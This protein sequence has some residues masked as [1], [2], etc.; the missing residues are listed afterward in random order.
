MS[1]HD[2]PWKRLHSTVVYENPWIRVEDHAVVNPAGGRGQYGKVCFKSRAIG[3]APIDAADHIYL[4]GQYRYTLDSYSWELPM[5]GA[6]PGEDPLVAGQRELREETGLE[7]KRWRHLLTVHTSNSV[8]DE[9]GDVFVARELV[10]GTARP[11]PT[12]A[13]AVQRMPFAQALE[14][15]L[16][17]KIT[18]AM[19]VAAILRLAVET[20]GSA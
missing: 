9:V 2:N 17:G 12:E 1:E 5:G 11:E 10:P 6:A 3:I 20:P 4:V 16:D 7:A 13:L 15:V 19:S 8:T 14:W 18:D